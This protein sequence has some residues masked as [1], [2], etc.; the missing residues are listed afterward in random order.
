[1]MHI[2]AH[3]NVFTDHTTISDVTVNDDF[4]CFFLEDKDRKLEDGGEKV[5][6]KTAIPRGFYNIVM[7]FSP[8]YQ[9]NM[10]HILDVPGFEGVRI[11]PGNKEADTEGCLLPGMI[12]KDDFVEKSVIAYEKI[13]SMMISAWEAGEKVTLEIT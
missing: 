1:M 7:D 9:K 5:Y 6:G 2:K 8:K 12:Q 4:V 11:H 3:R 13:L 10:P